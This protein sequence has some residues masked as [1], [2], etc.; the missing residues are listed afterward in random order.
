[1]IKDTSTSLYYNGLQKSCYGQRKPLN[2]AI[3]QPKGTKETLQNPAGTADNCNVALEQLSSRMSFQL[4][5]EVL[6]TSDS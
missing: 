4:E 3:E 6:D 5:D 2:L 1:M